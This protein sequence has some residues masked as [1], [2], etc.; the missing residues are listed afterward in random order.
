MLAET[1]DG[2][3][4]RGTDGLGAPAHGVFSGIYRAKAWAEP[5]GDG[6]V[7]ARD[8]G[9]GR[10]RNR[11]HAFRAARGVYLMHF[12]KY[13]NIAALETQN[14]I[15]RIVGIC[16]GRACR[17]CVEKQTR[18]QHGFIAILG[19]AI[20]PQSC[21]AGARSRLCDDK[22]RPQCV[23]AKENVLRA[24]STVIRTA[25]H[26]ARLGG[27]DLWRRLAARGSLALVRGDP[28]P[29]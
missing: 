14:H 23:D 10:G 18:R 16:R 28:A 12:W 25:G 17:G 19:Q 22:T 2:Q 13:A 29:S 21:G 15:A 7:A 4:V 8:M 20:L 6:A 11:N 9:S 3:R 24:K 1:L 26:L 27:R 5:N